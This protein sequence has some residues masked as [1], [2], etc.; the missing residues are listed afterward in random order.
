MG[1]KSVMTCT[2]EGGG[3]K[4]KKRNPTHKQ[5]PIFTPSQQKH[6]L[7]AWAEIPVGSSHTVCP[8][9][10]TDISSDD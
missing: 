1:Q 8:G 6:F 3:K 9:K 2:W 5:S 7:H 10:C 4:K